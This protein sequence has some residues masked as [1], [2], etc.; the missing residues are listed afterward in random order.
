MLC[1]FW[2]HEFDAEE[3]VETLNSKS[4]RLRQLAGGG[5]GLY[6]LDADVLLLLLCLDDMS[7]SW[8]IWPLDQDWLGWTEGYLI[9][10]LIGW[11]GDLLAVGEKGKQQHYLL[12]LKKGGYQ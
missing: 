12:T 3:H 9:G 6:T 1:L 8:K 10:E 5:G 2:N 7:L 4:Q 11:L